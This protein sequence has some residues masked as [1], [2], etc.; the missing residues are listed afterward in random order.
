[1]AAD[2]A[3]VGIT[4]QLQTTDWAVYLD[5]RKN[6]Q[7]SLY[8]LG[9]T[10]DNGDPDNFVCYFFCKPGAS[11]EGFYSNPK[12]AEVLLQ[13]Q[14]L[15]DVKKRAELYRQAEQMIHDDVARIFVA[16]NQPPL[17]FQKKVRGYVANPTGA[18]H[19][20]TVFFQ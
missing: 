10:G 13:A 18:E 4:V 3:K 6:G 20:N 16:N 9:W 17:A 2:L 1:M 19:F 15:T 7:L 14:R 11:T 12:L 5:K 8:M